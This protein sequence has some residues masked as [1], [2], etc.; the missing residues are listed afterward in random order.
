MLIEK[1]KKTK[2]VEFQ[3]EFS[4]IKFCLKIP[5]FIFHFN[6]EKT[7]IVFFEKEH[8][9]FDKERDRTSKSAK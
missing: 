1:E 6:K 4:Q 5:E 7:E 8:E 9:E 3:K 2:S